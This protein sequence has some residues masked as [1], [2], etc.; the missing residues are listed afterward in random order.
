VTVFAGAGKACGKTAAFLAAAM[1][2]RRGPAALF[3]I[4]FD[5]KGAAV[6]V[7]PGDTVITTVPLAR[8]AGAGLEVI[9]ALPGRSAVGRLCVCRA[10]RAGTVALVGPEHLGQLASA[11]EMVR[12]ENLV[13]SVLVDGAAGRLTQAGALPDAQ[14]VYCARVDRSNFLRAAENIELV[15]RLADLPTEGVGE[16]GESGESGEPKGASGASQALRLEGP[17]TPS[18]LEGLPKDATHVSIG[19]LSDCFLDAP[20]FDR[21][22]RRIEI[23]VRRRIPLLCFAVALK[24]IKRE[25]FLAA[26]PAAAGRAAFD[27]YG[28]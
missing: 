9:D 10:V 24:D 20:S 3:T 18:V 8:A 12:Q 25:A 15:S 6:G 11:V 14:V 1:A 19:S 27:L 26:A 7:G 22:A 21:A 16:S 17:L 23:T 28:V 2:R 5:A 13:E 4:G